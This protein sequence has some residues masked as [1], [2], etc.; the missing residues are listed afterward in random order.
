[1]MRYSGLGVGEEEPI[2]VHSFIFNKSI[3]LFLAM[4][5]YKYIRVHFLKPFK[6]VCTLFEQ[7]REKESGCNGYLLGVLQTKTL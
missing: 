7:E 2:E 6:N 4:F 3:S 1:M 5:F